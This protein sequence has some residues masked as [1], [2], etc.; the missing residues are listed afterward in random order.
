VIGQSIDRLVAVWE[1]E[2]AAEGIAAFLEKRP[3]RWAAG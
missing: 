1:S 3:P 2:E